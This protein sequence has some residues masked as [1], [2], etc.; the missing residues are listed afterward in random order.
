MQFSAKHIL[1]SIRAGINILLML[2]MFSLA[3]AY[4][5]KAYAQTS[6]GITDEDR[7]KALTIANTIYSKNLIIATN[8][9]YANLKQYDKS[10]EAKLQT[11]R[12]I[13]MD[14]I[15]YR[16]SL[17]AEK[18]NEHYRKEAVL[19]KSA[20]DLDIAAINTIFIQLSIN[21]FNPETAEGLINT[22]H[23]YQSSTNWF[24]ANRAYTI[25]AAYN[26]KS[27][28][29]STALT[30]VQMA[31][32][33]IPTTP[34]PNVK[35]AMYETNDMIAYLY[36][37]V[38]NPKLG[39]AATEQVVLQGMEMGRNVDGIGHIGNLAY[40]FEKWRDYK[41]A[42]DLTEIIIALTK[43]N[44]LGIN[45]I[46][47]LRY[48]Q[49]LNNTGE[50]AKAKPY[51]LDALKIEKNVR[52]ELSLE[53]QLAISLAG[54]G[55]THGTNASFQRFDVLA[56]KS[57]IDIT[58]FNKRKLHAE[59]LLAV[60]RND[61][62]ATY[63]LVNT[64]LNA[65]MEQTFKRINLTAQS[66][67][68]ELEN[69]KQ[70]QQEREAAQE[71]E[72]DLQQKELDAKQRS[73][74]L[75]VSLA[76]SLLF[77]TLAAIAIAVWRQRTNRA[78]TTA[79]HVAKAGDRA[80]SQFLSVMSHELRTPL[81]GIIGISGLLYEYGET[82]TL[83][84][85]NKIILDSGH[86]LLEILN[87]IIDMSQME[88]GT[89]DIVTAP[90]NI[91]Q[92]ADGLY[93]VFKP[94]IDT[95]QI[96]FTCHVAKDIPEDIML[97][98]IRIKQA[99]SNL[100]SNAIKFTEQGRIH[101]HITLSE[102][103]SLVS[104]VR[105]LNLIIADT[106]QGISEGAKSK[107]FKP[108]IQADTSITRNHG[109]A[110]VGL[111]V[112]RG[113]ARLM[114]GDITMSS[115]PG[116]GTEFV[117]TVKTCSAQDAT[118]DE[119]TQRPNFTAEPNTEQQVVDFSPAISFEKLK[120]KR[121]AAAKEK[122]EK[123]AQKALQK[124]QEN[125]AALASDTGA[126]TG[127]EPE[128]PVG[129][130]DIMPQELLP[131]QDISE[132]SAGDKAP[133]N[134]QNENYQSEEA[135]TAA[136]LDIQDDTETDFSELSRLLEPDADVELETV[137]NPDS[138]YDKKP[139][140][141]TVTEQ[142]IVTEPVV[143]QPPEIAVTQPAVPEPVVEAV[144]PE[145]APVTAPTPYPAPAMTQAQA[146]IAP[147]PIAP[148][149]T[150]TP[151]LNA[152]TNV[153]TPAPTLTP[154]DPELQLDTL[155]LE[156]L[157][158]TEPQTAELQPAKPLADEP[159]RG[160]TRRTPREN[161]GAISH[162]KLEG[163]NILVVEDLLANQVVLRALLE[164]VGCQ[165]TMAEHGKKALEIMETQIFDVILMDIRM[166][167]MNGIETTENIRKNPGPHQHVPIIAL[168]ADA[169]AENNAQCLAAGA[170]VFLTK[171]VIVSELFSS[172]RF[173][174]EKQTRQSTT[175]TALSA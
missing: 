72:I 159:R 5:E 28:R 115:T 11:L 155:Q 109:G 134:Y 70:R 30:Q 124:E 67:L 13:A 41:T 39:I 49:S 158:A 55:D 141:E 137:I 62:A 38:N 110:G 58:G 24:V 103:E 174:R 56:K 138:F 57:G 163:L 54:M 16:N 40:L 53:A 25:E 91:Y 142:H 153:P 74:V 120:A 104:P 128:S 29:L 169:S 36:I 145:A 83:R 64:Q 44:N 7:A 171:P 151:E 117:M 121:E 66:Q 33:L 85:Q 95:A 47:Y 88:S 12:Q 148:A 113:L 4:S 45:S 22:L 164:P 123:K 8:L 114:G 143:T 140:V 59:A 101:I 167:I 79:A 77:I 2:T 154:V 161:T 173:V 37:L 34:G 129:P 152:P 82:Q 17:D 139:A 156:E 102:P 133:E 96:Q 99:L 6:G 106:G 172:I 165:I 75:L 147:A 69:S 84:D 136:S 135:S 105:T 61:A 127:T 157:Q 118:F 1:E 52:I 175:S 166:P 131:K 87:G 92:L 63:K 21:T 14:T 50:Y 97:D 81:N 71:R 107:L 100:I 68:A 10:P 73:V 168:T 89:L 86:N 27:L 98:S 78:L 3:Y 149:A 160:F 76:G 119:E 126:D 112:T 144:I 170:D 111:A 150:V 60:A 132:Q 26:G 108:F 32:Q 93:R 43:K 125:A 80:K 116:R 31:H 90:T 48:A 46:A 122:Q 23:R 19:Q 162:D 51:L 35:E 65:E 9:A 130:E 42:S 146:P 18:I 94:Q 20:A 15:S